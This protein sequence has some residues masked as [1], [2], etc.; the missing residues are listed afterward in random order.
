VSAGARSRGGA[1][2]FTLL[3]VL[4]ATALLGIG[5]VA[6]LSLLNGSLRL[7]QAAAELR[8]DAALA[9]ELAALQGLPPEAGAAELER[10]LRERYPERAFRL[11][12]RP[13]QHPAVQQVE[14]LVFRGRAEGEA[15]YRLVLFVEAEERP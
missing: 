8:K 10:E 9:A 7:A 3:E 6:V 15:A 13:T 1:A 11:Q 5:L 14:I 2:G 12:R 4:V